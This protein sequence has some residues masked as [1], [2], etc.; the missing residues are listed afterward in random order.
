MPYKLKPP[1]TRGPCW[2]VRGSD[3]GGEYEASTGKDTERD[4]AKWVEEVYL[5]SR[6]SRR[7]PGAGEPVGFKAAAAFYK[8]FK[9]LS[10]A[11]A[12]LVD[13]VA[14]ELGDIDCRALT[15]AHLVAAANRLRPKGKDSTK[16]RKVI[17]PAAA[18]LHYA[19]RQEWCSYRVIEKFAES[20]IS[21]R[22]PATDADMA[23][24]FKHLADPPSKIAPQWYGVDPNLPY[25]RL[26]LAMLY[27]LGLRL[28]DLL[29]IDW[30][31]VDL[32]KA[33]LT[34][35]IRKT[36]KVATLSLSRV[37]VA[38]LANLPRKTGHLLPWTTSRGV[39]AWL[40]RVRARAK[41]HYTPH[42][43]RHAMATA[44]GE[45]RIPDAEA[46]KLGAWADVRSLHRYQHVRPEPIPGRNAGFLMEPGR[47][48]GQGR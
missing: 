39:Y 41:I 26:L 47:K 24:L 7:L 27:E 44:A 1:G 29:A 34:V 33:K 21:N 30:S 43:S 20:R 36:D 12:K 17:N 4:A 35:R 9:K 15:H 13:A 11:D 46:A 38:L 5:P 25:K 16:N 14:E 8:A 48:R 31:Q 18:V 40:D 23:K 28:G 6:A 37:L 45:R 19:S 32:K 3:S 2:Y 10:K 42:L 22:T